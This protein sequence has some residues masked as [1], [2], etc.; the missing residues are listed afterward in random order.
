MQ[1]AKKYEWQD[2]NLALFGSQ[3]EKDVKKEAA[4]TEPAWKGCGQKVGL[5]IWRIVKFKV[6]HWNK[7]DYGDFFDG[8]S[9]IILNTFKEEDSEELNY[10]VHFWIGKHSTQDEY[11][12]AAYKTVELDTYLDD[13][14]VQ[15]R[16]V[17]NKES[18]LFKTY[19]KRLT[20]MNGGADSGFR[21]VK[22]E[23][24]PPRLLH[25]HMEG[26]GRKACLKINEERKV[27]KKCLRS[28]DVYFLDGGTKM[29]MWCG[30]SSKH[31]E[32]FKAAQEF[33]SMTAKRPRAVKESLDEDEI[34]P[35]H[36]FWDFFTDDDDDDDSGDDVDADEDAD[37]SKTFE[38][39]LFRLSNSSGVLDFT[40]VSKGN[41]ICRSDLDSNDV[42]ILD[43]GMDCFVWAGKDADKEEKNN[44]I[45]YATEYLKK[46][47]HR[48]A[49]ISSLKEGSK[50]KKF[51]ELIGR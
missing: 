24:Y 33:Q 8:D 22:P 46:T 16:E 14:P 26:K 36:P 17:M 10:D 19:F 28:D 47:L 50:C 48:N 45:P 30:S 3:T 31:D 25:C 37:D 44:G 5:Q 43:T 18:D 27:S 13:K 15:H 51:T 49:P 34:S 21:H 7:E 38:S 20:Y 1:K 9:Y 12:T 32:R 2:T 4:E 39:V 35:D 11:G 23:E 42:F 41:N 6:E 29:F 40:E